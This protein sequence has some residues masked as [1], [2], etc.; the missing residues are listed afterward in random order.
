M[1]SVT[2]APN[3]HEQYQEH[4]GQLL[5]DDSRK[6]LLYVIGCDTI[7]IDINLADI[8]SILPL[9]E[10]IWDMSGHNKK[11]VQDIIVNI[12]NKNGYRFHIDSAI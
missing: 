4:S 1:V 7:I 2:R 11:V 3:C 10:N 5:I 8:Q 9:E 6:K 12:S